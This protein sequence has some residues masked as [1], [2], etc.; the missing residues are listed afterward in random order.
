MNFISVVCVCPCYHLILNE[1]DN[2]N[3]MDIIEI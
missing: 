3:T 2:R 1:L